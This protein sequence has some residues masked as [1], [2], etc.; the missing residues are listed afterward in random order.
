MTERVLPLDL[1]NIRSYQVDGQC[2]VYLVHSAVNAAVFVYCESK[3]LVQIVCSL[4]DTQALCYD[5]LVLVLSFARLSA[6][7]SK[8][9]FMKRLHAQGLL[10]FVVVVVTYVPPTVSSRVPLLIISSF[11]TQVFAFLNVDRKIVS[12]KIP[13]RSNV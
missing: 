11:L 3:T 5:F 4:Q 8:S 12:F 2:N 1:A 10:Y 7:S 13:H 6:Q 9:P